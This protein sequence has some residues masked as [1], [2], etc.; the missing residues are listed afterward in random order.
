VEVVIITTSTLPGLLTV[1]PRCD[2]CM[3]TESSPLGGKTLH[4]R[5]CDGNP[6]IVLAPCRSHVRVFRSGKT[7]LGGVSGDLGRSVG[8]G[9]ELGGST[10]GV[11]EEQSW[12]RGAV[13]HH[14]RCGMQPEAMDTR[15]VRHDTAH[16]HRF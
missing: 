10:D 13:P 12:R 8:Q 15:K 5:H 16:R 1:K 7:L 2:A 11:T 6:K 9:R 3:G 4:G 14:I